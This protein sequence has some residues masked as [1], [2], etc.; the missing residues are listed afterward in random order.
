MSALYKTSLGDM[1]VP[2]LIKCVDRSG[3]TVHCEAL[4]PSASC[5]QL[6]TCLSQV[7]VK[8]LYPCIPLKSTVHA[9]LVCL[10]VATAV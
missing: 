8:S 10:N 9:C 3:K 2:M 5:Q 1:C 7:P 6:V 4:P